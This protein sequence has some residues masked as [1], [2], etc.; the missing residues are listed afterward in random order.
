[1]ALDRSRR[2]SSQGVSNIIA[3]FCHGIFEE[4]FTRLALIPLLAAAAVAQTAPAPP[5][6]AVS[7]QP[8]SPAPAPFARPI[9]PQKSHRALKVKPPYEVAENEVYIS[10]LKQMKDQEWYRLR[11][12]SIVQTD[13]FL[14]KADDIDYNEDTG[15]VDARGSVY[16]QY[17]AGGEELWCDHAV[18]NV[19]DE[20]GKFY[21]VRGQA[22]NRI[23][24]RPRVLTSSNPF[25]FEGK[26]A[27]RLKEKYILHDGFITNCKMPT[28]WWIV[29]GP[30]FDIIPGDRAISHRSIFFLRRIPLFYAPYYYKSLEK[31]PRQSGFLTPNI[32]NSSRRGMM[33]GGGYYWAINRSYDVAYRAQYFTTRGFA[34]NMDFRGK[35]TEHSS[36]NGFIYGVQDRGEWGSV[37]VIGPGGQTTTVRKRINQNP[38]YVLSVEGDS[39]LGHGFF[40]KG[41]LNYLSS[42]GFRQTFTETYTEGTS[43]EIA[44]VGFITRQWSTLSLDFVGQRLEN[45]LS[46]KTNDFVA[47]H[48]FPEVEFRSRDRRI[49]KNVPIWVSWDMTGG[50]LGRKDI[51]FRTPTFVERMDVNPRVTTALHW[52]DFGIVPSF[53]VRESHYGQSLELSGILGRNITR[54]GR[55]FDLQ[56]VLPSLAR[57]YDGPSWLGDKV[58]HVIEPG[59]TYKYVTGVDVF[60]QIV[61]F[62][63]AELFSNTNQVEVSL[64]NRLYAKRG[65]QVNEILSWDL[66][67]QRYFDPTFGGAVT[68][69]W[70]DKPE[71]GCRNVVLSSIELTPYAF[72][73][74]PRN[75]SPIVSTL[76]TSP[77][78]GFGFEWRSDYDPLR[79]NL[80][81][82]SFSADVRRGR[83][84][85]S[86]GQNSMKAVPGL[87]PNANQFRGQIGLGNENRRGWNAGF[88]SIYDYRLGRWQYATTQVTYNTDCCGFSIQ[89]QRLSFGIRNDNQF[90]IAF[91]VANI[92][93]FGTLKK[94]E[95]MF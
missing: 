46:A 20:S 39:S 92:G 61:R 14:M 6:P 40:A 94:Q 28:P 93:S 1:M 63:T 90:R 48:K 80:V 22:P 84:F 44:S 67:Q 26:W 18:Y 8:A 11:G 85:L 54:T 34:H 4:K 57:I 69:N 10:A 59:V 24:A 87:T 31:L 66:R 7:V 74:G 17:F 2:E 21:N 70:C 38:G 68:S 55:E 45:F 77:I 53:A 23:E 49:W 88:M 81:A 75:Y 83:Y 37:N 41:E 65:D 33:F 78:S 60:D 30:K 5:P 42:F 25:Y 27:E 50:L 29:R 91:G 43:S 56:L 76:R 51:D 72:L 71:L 15:D 19:E 35:P 82:S 62:D 12:N 32:G 86:A 95:R 9:A 58:K 73:D 89:Y 47:I 13:T 16:L 36:F 64:T 3:G 79:H 52:K